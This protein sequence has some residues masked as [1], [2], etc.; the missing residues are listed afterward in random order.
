MTEWSRTQTRDF[1][2]SL[3]VGQ[4][5]EISWRYGPQHAADGR[6]T[7]QATKIVDWKGTVVVEDTDPD[8]CKR[9]VIR[10]DPAEGLP[11]GG[12]MTFPP[13]TLPGRTVDIIR[14]T[15]TAPPSEFPDLT[16]FLHQVAPSPTTGAATAPTRTHSAAVGDKRTR[17]EFELL[18]DA[19]KQEG[20]KTRLAEGLKVP[21]EVPNKFAVFYPNL[22]LDKA[23]E[24]WSTELTATLHQFGVQLHTASLRNDMYWERDAFIAWLGQGTHPVTKDD[25]YVPFNMATRII[26]L[27]A[28]ALRGYKEETALRREAHNAFDL[29]YINFQKLWSAHVENGGDDR[30]NFRPPLSQSRGGGRGRGY[31]RGRARGNH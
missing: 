30:K 28:G 17:E 7:S 18:A 31:F 3:E 24:R 29:G 19:F 21:T 25:W 23:P 14:G 16:A 27:C 5:V 20:A 9:V 22:W 11:E 15:A 13:P 10:Y 6:V 12:A 26:G 1:A 8:G 4:I 2:N